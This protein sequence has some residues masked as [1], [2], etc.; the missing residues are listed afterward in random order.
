MTE[1]TKTEKEIEQHKQ[2]IKKLRSQLRGAKTLV[3]EQ[4]KFFGNE[5]RRQIITLI[6]S[7]FGFVAALLWRDAV[8]SFLVQTFQIAPG[9]GGTWVGQ[10]YVALL[11]TFFVIVATVFITNIM[12]MPSQQTTK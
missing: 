1:E 6:T 7:A 2:E 9:Q 5:T 12:K 8:Q 11:V 4:L 3:K 10:A